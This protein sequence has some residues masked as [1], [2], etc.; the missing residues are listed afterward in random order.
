M[1]R[2][3]RTETLRLHEKLQC[4]QLC[5]VSHLLKLWIFRIGEQIIY[6]LF[7]HRMES[8]C[9]RGV[10]DAFCLKPHSAD[11]SIQIVTPSW[12]YAQGN[13]I[14]SD[15]SSCSDKKKVCKWDA[16]LYAD[17]RRFMC[18]RGKTFWQQL[19]WEFSFYIVALEIFYGGK[20]AYSAIAHEVQ[21][22]SIASPGFTTVFVRITDFSQSISFSVP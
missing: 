6:G 9:P 14:T 20:T 10:L 21:Q 13:K 15:N 22:V 19:S 18:L 8:P 12:D 1:L 11:R 16:F 17:N 2:Q 7:G 5:S 4:H 3:S